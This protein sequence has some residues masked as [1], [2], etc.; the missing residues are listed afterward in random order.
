MR[1][2]TSS[3]MGQGF[4]KSVLFIFSAWPILGIHENLLN[5]GAM[6]KDLDLISNCPIKPRQPARNEL[7]PNAFVSSAGEK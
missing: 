6:R 1:T 5:D 7:F 4:T 3:I 2:P